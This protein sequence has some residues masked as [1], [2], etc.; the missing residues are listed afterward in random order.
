MRGYSRSLVG[1]MAA[2]GRQPTP[3]AV[4]G[5]AEVGFL[6]QHQ[7]QTQFQVA[8]FPSKLHGRLKIERERI[9]SERV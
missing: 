1:E 2:P 5:G 4:A 3:A 6:L 7:T 8:S 9:I